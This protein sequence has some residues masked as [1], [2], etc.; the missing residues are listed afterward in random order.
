MQLSTKAAK[1]IF[2]LTA[3]ILVGLSAVLYQHIDSLLKS[4]KELNRTAELKLKLE[5]L[6]GSL[7]DTETAQRGFLLTQDSLFLDPYHGAYARSKALLAQINELAG[8]D[9]KPKYNALQTFVAVRFGTFTHLFGKFR[10]PATTL[11]D[12]RIY[13][14]HSKAT[15]DSIRF[16]VNNIGAKA[17]EMYRNREKENRRYTFLAPFYALLLMAFA[18]AI[19]I[20]SYER[21]LGHLKRTR[22]LLFRL[23]K[24]NNKLKQ[25][26]HRLELTNKEL[27]SFT[28][29]ASH[30]LKEPLRKILTYISMIEHKEDGVSLQDNEVF[31]QKIKFSA[32]RMQNLLDDLLYYSHASSGEK[33]F[34]TVDL[35]KIVKE[36]VQ[37][38]DEEIT[39]SG[40]KIK[41]NDLPVI[42]GMPFQIKQLFENLLSNSLK[43]RQQKKPPVIT[44]NSSVVG[45]KEVPDD[46]HKTSASYVKLL[47]SDNGVG[48]EQSYADRIFRLFQRLH[49]QEGYKGTGIGLTICKKVVDNHNGFIHAVSQVNKGTTFE[50]YFPA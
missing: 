18:V 16:Y 30:D 34:E 10:D 5:Q 17:D 44:I 29:V 15:M 14:R 11:E 36:V 43:Y 37:N 25:Q 48:F 39:E 40:A 41:Y 9:E 12:K 8:P 23:K 24:L 4:Q 27:D 7:I 42:K 20:F 19:L 6:L 47:F 31:F 33:Q 50:I 45:E 38:L 32:E 1:G 3:V 2:I 26:N 22:K 28:Y 35:N 13:L 21:I 49:T 46:H